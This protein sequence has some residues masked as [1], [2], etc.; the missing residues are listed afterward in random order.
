MATR[1]RRPATAFLVL[2]LVAAGAAAAAAPEV[3]IEAGVLR[4]MTAG[5]VDAFKGIP[6][7]APP[8]GDLRWRAP[9]PAVPWPGVRDATAYGHDCVQLP[10]PGDA[11]A[12]GSS[13]AEDCLVLNVWRPASAG[14][15]RRLPVLVWIH[16]GGFVSGAASVPL[17]DGSA[18]ARDGVVLVGINY[19]LG[20]LGFF[21]HPALTAAH[22]GPL[23]NY[24]LMDQL[25]A[26]Q[27]VRRNV[28]AFGG[29]PDA[30]TVAG[31]SAGGI[32]VIHLLTSPAARGLFRRA[33]VLSGGGRTYLLPQRA[34]S[35]TTGSL[36]SAEASG[37]AFAASAG[38]TGT[39]AAALRALR[40][41]PAERVSG[42]LGMAALL[43]LPATYTGGPVR[44]GVIVTAQPEAAFRRGAFAPVPLVI[45]TTQDDLGAGPPPADF[46]GPDAEQARRAYDPGGSLGTA[47]V[48]A[49]V[50]EDLTMHEPARFVARAMTQAGAPAWLYR[51][52][53]VAEALRAQTDSAGHASEL[54]YVFARLDARYGSAVTDA[55]R[56]M[57]ALV[58][59][60]FANFVRH[61]DPNGPGLPAWPRFDP[62]GFDLM[63]FTA[64]GAR[65][66]PDPWRGRLALVERALARRQ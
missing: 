50:A 66:T 11:G 3:R 54:A 63:L 8:V 4:G 46:F 12:S 37:L 7:A 47:M 42:D 25:A 24:G 6:Y 36:P 18:F 15:G 13:R 59:G 23:A 38:I 19:R 28:A 55:D 34:L 17:F 52:D 16:G 49:L 22:E 64:T 48:A 56:R 39:D 60:Y 61:G 35:A 1:V 57:A 10:A 2:V 43:D 21:A 45:G 5:G 51:F 31:E 20:R 14:P 40:A 32:A 41:L 62:A 30:V 26:L 58:H 53:Y 44:D 27:W 9:Q 29:D 33:A 65:V